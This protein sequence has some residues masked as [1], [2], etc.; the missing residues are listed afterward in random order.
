[1]SAKVAWLYR[2]KAALRLVRKGLAQARK[3]QFTKN[4]PDLEADACLANRLADAE[5]ALAA[6]KGANWRKVRSNV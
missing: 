2:N 4:P 6:G 1:M 3:K 5:K